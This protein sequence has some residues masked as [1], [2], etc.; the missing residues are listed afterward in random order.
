MNTT[1]RSVWLLL[2]A[3]AMLFLTSCGDDDEP[4]ITPG[5]TDGINVADGL[6]LAAEGEDPSST[7]LL[8]TENV[9]AEGFTSQA[10]TGFVGGYVYLDAGNYNVVQITEKEVTATIGGSAESVTDSSSDCDFNDYTVITT[11]AGGSAINVATAGLYRVTHDQTTS[12]LIMYAIDSPGLIGDATPG[13]WSSDTR[14]AGSIASDGAS[15]SASDVVLRNGQWKVRFNCRWSLDRRT[16]PAA[17]FGMENGYQLYTNFGGAANDLQNGNDSPN[18]A[19]EEEGT[20]TVTITWDPRS[21]FAVDLDRTGDAPVISF[22]PN[23]FQWGVIGSATAGGWDADRNLLPKN[24][25]GVYSW[26]GVVTL[27]SG[28]GEEIK[29]RTNDSWDLNLGGTLTADGVASELV[30]GGDNIPSPGSGSYYVVIST[31]DEGDTWMAT[32]TNLGWS[33]IGA[34]SPSGNWDN[35]TDLVADGFADGISTY[36]LTADFGSDEW[37]FRAGHAWDLNL[38]GDLGTLIQD[39]GNLKFSEAGNYTVTFTFDGADYSASAQKN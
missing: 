27:I 38:G 23:D 10:R 19:Q 22:D 32:M 11:A 5:G 20:Y 33:V 1:L 21:G 34:G 9:E 15:W 30:N 24:A 37:K 8:S 4:V 12:E 13:G 16:D 31:A 39:G 25:D 36:S 35:D 28:E 3:F 17:G 26:H 7:A 29:F 6:Y 14:L 2:A 18:I